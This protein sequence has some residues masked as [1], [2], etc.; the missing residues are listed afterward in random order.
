MPVKKKYPKLAGL[1]IAE[2]ETPQDTLMV[3][4]WKDTRRGREQD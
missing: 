3:Q 4:I 1:K 2:A